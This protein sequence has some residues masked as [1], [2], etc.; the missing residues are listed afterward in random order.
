MINKLKKRL[1]P[2]LEKS[3]IYKRD[4]ENKIKYGLHAPVH[5]E[6]IWINPKR[7]NYYI[8]KDEIVNV[9]G[10]ERQESSGIVIDWDEITQVIPLEN[11]FR[12]RYAF[13]RWK[14][15]MDWEEIGVYEY[16]K[17]NTKKYK[18]YSIKQLEDRFNGFDCI[19]NEI[20]KD[21]RLKSRKEIDPS[22]FREEDGVLIH[23]GKDGELFFGGIGFH[24]LSIA[25]VLG[26]EK[27]PACLGVVDKHS[28]H[29]LKRLRSF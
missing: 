8:S 22:N 10:K 1:K 14:E 13:M 25:K 15:G 2:A 28:L 21:G 3:Q 7:V 20:K 4:I 12:Y 9:T 16:M 27:I 19:F 11:D 18:D 23:I 17:N 5:L 26:L 29:L 6:R 24:R